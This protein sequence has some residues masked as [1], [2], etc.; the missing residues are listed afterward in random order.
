MTTE[1]LSSSL[2]INQLIVDIVS[3]FQK[4]QNTNSLSFMPRERRAA[5]L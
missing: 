2:N 4:K 1:K 5:S 3:H